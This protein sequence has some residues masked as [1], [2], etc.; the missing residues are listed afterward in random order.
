LK[1]F[2]DISWRFS[3]THGEMLSLAT[4]AKYMVNPEGLTDDSPLAVYDSEF[5]EDTP[6][7]ALV[8][9]YTVPPCFSNDLFALANTNTTR[10]RCRRPPYRWILMGPARSGTGLHI[11][12]LWTNAWV[13]LLQGCKRWLLFPPDTPPELIGMK[14]DEAQKIPSS[15]WFYRYYDKVTSHDFPYPPVHVLQR[16]GETV[17]VPS[18]WPHLVLNLELVVAVT[19]NYACEFGPFERMWKEVVTEEPEFAIDWFE[20]LMKH[21]PDLAQRIRESHPDTIPNYSSLL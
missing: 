17:F 9:E 11:D 6:T 10:R 3:D 18:S 2:G 1:R 13:T 21:R 20:G 12:P 14:D 8:E 19:H 7:N 15:V 16:V 5:G 4:Y